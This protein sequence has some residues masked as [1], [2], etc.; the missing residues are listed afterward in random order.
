MSKIINGYNDFKLQ[1]SIWNF[2]RKYP[3]V[4]DLSDETFEEIK[5]GV[6]D[7]IDNTK[8]TSSSG[9]LTFNAIRLDVFRYLINNSEKILDYFIR[10]NLTRGVHIPIE[11]H[12]IIWEKQLITKKAAEYFICRDL[13][14]EESS[15]RLFE[16]IA[17]K[18]N[19][20]V[21][22][23]EF[24]FAEAM[25]KYKISV[26]VDI[27]LI[28]KLVWNQDY[29]IVQDFLDRNLFTVNR[30]FLKAMTFYYNIPEFKPLFKAMRNKL[31]N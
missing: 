20:S 6:E 13:T 1:D 22:E 9:F 11:I 2:V 5:K 26:P 24:K 27:K 17:K 21:T 10:T 12:E 7:I 4:F 18:Y 8:F 14:K 25:S 31:Y 23:R 3:Y 16:K 30:D 29:K 28:E 19:F 15:I